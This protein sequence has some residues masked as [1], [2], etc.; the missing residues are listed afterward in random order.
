MQYFETRLVT[1][2]LLKHLGVAKYAGV[3]GRNN[4]TLYTELKKD[5]LLISN[6]NSAVMC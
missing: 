5:L 4:I 1:L 3:F 6:P 2:Q